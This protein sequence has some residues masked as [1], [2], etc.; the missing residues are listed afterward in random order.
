MT[1]ST[2]RRLQPS[3]EPV[4]LSPKTGELVYRCPLCGPED[5]SGHLYLDP[6]E[7][8]WHCYRCNNGG[9][10]SWLVWKTGIAFPCN[11]GPADATKN[12]V[13]D[14]LAG[15]VDSGVLAALRGDF[16]QAVPKVKRHDGED[17]A[18]LSPD[19]HGWFSK[20][21]GDLFGLGNP[22]Y[23]FKLS[24]TPDDWWECD[25]GAQYKFEWPWAQVFNGVRYWRG[26]GYDKASA[27][28]WR[29]FVP[30]DPCVSTAGT[31]RYGRLVVPAIHPQAGCITSFMA[32]AT[33]SKEW[34][35]YLGPYTRSAYPSLIFSPGAILKASIKVL[36]E[37]VLVEGPFDAIAVSRAG[38]DVAALSGKALTVD[39]IAMLK[40][41]GVNTVIV[42]L[43]SDSSTAWHSIAKKLYN[44]GVETL[45]TW[46]PPVKKDPGEMDDYEIHMLVASAIPAW[47]AFAAGFGE[48]FS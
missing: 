14:M 30:T 20:K 16:N 33:T 29:V 45:V 26:R 15:V 44:S 11:E 41:S 6:D 35:K 5:Q 18:K 17:Y 27:Q 23:S 7:G 47:Q 39:G 48:S 21:A 32:R 36:R 22:A 34:P 12:A 9:R 42:M 8:V 46:L 40:A 19:D 24:N 13:A 10:I 3:P 4:R 25:L 2:T 37:V 31:T 1:V 38:Y 28:A 43:D